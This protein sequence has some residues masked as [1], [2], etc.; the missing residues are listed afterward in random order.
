MDSFNVVGK[1]KMDSHHV[2]ILCSVNGTSLDATYFI[3]L[4]GNTHTTA[5]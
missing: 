2:T 3:R 5:S 1:R 4:E